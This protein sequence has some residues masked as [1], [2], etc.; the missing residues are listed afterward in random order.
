MIV[1]VQKLKKNY[2]IRDLGVD[3]IVQPDFETSLA[4]IRRIY[5]LNR[6]DKI[7]MINKIKRLKIEQGLV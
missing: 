6:V 4:V 5:H 2:R 1:K 7:D 3:Q